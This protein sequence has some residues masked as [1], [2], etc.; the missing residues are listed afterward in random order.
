MWNYIE[1]TFGININELDLEIKSDRVRA[2]ITKFEEVPYFTDKMKLLCESGFTG[3]DLD[4]ILNCIPMIFKNYYITLGKDRILSIG[5]QK[6]KLDLE[7]E[8]IKNNQQNNSSLEELIYSIFQ[9]GE[10]YLK[11]DIKNMLSDI[12]NKSEIKATAKASDLENYFETK[13]YQITNKLTG[14]RDNGYEILRKKF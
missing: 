12:Y 5:C 8:R 13:N 14:K 1:S 10:K 11:S 7:Y 2:F 9:V 6:S 4:D 3:R